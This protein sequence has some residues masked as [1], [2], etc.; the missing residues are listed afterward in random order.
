MGLHHSS[1][2]VVAD[3]RSPGQPAKHKLPKA[4]HSVSFQN[5]PATWQKLLPEGCAAAQELR[6]ACAGK[7]K[8]ESNS[9]SQ[10]HLPQCDMIN[11]KLRRP[12]QEK[13]TGKRFF[14]RPAPTLSMNNSLHVSLTQILI[15]TSCKCCPLGFD[16]CPMTSASTTCFRFFNS[17][18]CQRRVVGTLFRHWIR[19]FLCSC[20]KPTTQISYQS[21]RSAAAFPASKTRV[22]K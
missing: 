7:D 9:C 21:S 5:L 16:C 15:N 13:N 12:H 1:R 2:L 4:A 11:L 17:R 19:L 22:K 6:A 18:L 20:P 3:S 14:F 10:K 8:G